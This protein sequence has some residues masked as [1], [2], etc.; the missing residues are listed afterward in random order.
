MLVSW[1]IISPTRLIDERE[2]QD[3]MLKE[4]SAFEDLRRLFF[5]WVGPGPSPVR[6]SGIVTSQYSTRHLKPPGGLSDSE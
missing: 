3:R 5:C 6:V 4:V 2:E 1:L